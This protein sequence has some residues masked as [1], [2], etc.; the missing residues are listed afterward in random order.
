MIP[1]GVVQRVDPDTK[2]IY[3]NMTKDEIKSAPDYDAERH[4]TDD[5]GYHK[6]LGNYSR[7]GPRPPGHRRQHHPNAS[8]NGQRVGRHAL[9]HRA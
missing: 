5:T 4:H 7:H 6:E 2:K 3:V 9:P 1:A 8:Q